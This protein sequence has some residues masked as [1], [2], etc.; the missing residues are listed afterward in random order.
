MEEADMSAALWK[1]FH[2]P[3]LAALSHHLSHR[4]ADKSQGSTFRAATGKPRPSSEPAS[5]HRL[6]ST[7]PS[8]IETYVEKV[9]LP[10]LQPSGC[11]DG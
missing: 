8:R 10:A 2:V 4:A 1:D 9:L 11:G 3:V 6:S 5:L 7:D